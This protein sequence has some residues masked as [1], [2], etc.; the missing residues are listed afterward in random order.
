MLRIPD[1]RWQDPERDPCNEVERG[2]DSELDRVT[3]ILLFSSVP[4]TVPTD[5]LYVAASRISSPI[6]RSASS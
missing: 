6:L 4:V 2:D 5:T 3:G 1:E